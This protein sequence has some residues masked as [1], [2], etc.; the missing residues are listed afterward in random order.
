MLLAAGE[1]LMLA[2]VLVFL[3]PIAIFA[4]LAITVL[5]PA[6][7]AAREGVEV[8]LLELVGMRLRRLDI[9]LVLDALVLAKEHDLHVSQIDVQ[10]AVARG[11]DVLAV[12]E[13]LARESQEA[14]STTLEELVEQQ[15]GGDRWR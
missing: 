11:A 12:I 7:R 15:L 3:A 10:R 14:K 4:L 8:N 5:R 13:A 9:D 1:M 2:V 6:M